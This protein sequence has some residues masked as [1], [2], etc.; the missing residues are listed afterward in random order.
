MNVKVL[1]AIDNYINSLGISEII[2][3][4]VLACNIS[5]I[6]KEFI[7][8]RIQS[9]SID[10]VVIDYQKNNPSDFF[11]INKIVEIDS[12]IKLFILTSRNV[13]PKTVKFSIK[14][15]IGI[16]L[17]TYS[18]INIIEL[19]NLPYLENKTR[20][21]VRF[22]TKTKT[23]DITSLLSDREFEIASMLVNGDSLTKISQK[24][25]LAITTISTFKRRVFEKTN[26]K[27]IIELA[28]LF[29]M[30]NEMEDKI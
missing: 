29:Y 2:S 27:N 24:L 30:H 4:C 11:L 10:I 20:K 16:I 12:K 1:I 8:Q 17:N 22:R 13:D 18:Y 9:R 23:Q 15:N 5:Q 19:F 3:D 14:N 6:P 21:P 7:I 28:K 25:N 26:V